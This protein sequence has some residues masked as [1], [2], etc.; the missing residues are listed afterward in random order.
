MPAFRRGRAIAVGIGLVMLVASFSVEYTVKRGDT[1]TKIAREH[2][3]SLSELISAN[4]LKNPD[5]IHPGQ[6]IVI[7]QKD[8]IHVVQR[9][10]TLIKLAAAYKT[11]VTTLVQANSIRNPDL[12]RVGQQLIIP[13]AAP[14]P[15]GASG[16]SPAPAPTS[17]GTR[18][19]AFHVVRSGENL[20]SIAARYPGVS[21]SQIAKANGII[22]GVIYTGT[23]LFL[24]GPEFVARA[25]GGEGVY[26]VKKGDRLGD[27][28]KAHGVT[29]SNLAQRN[30]ISNP[31]LIRVG[32]EL[33]VP[34]GSSWI[35]PVDGASVFNDWGFPRGATRFH[36]GNDLF[37]PHGTPVY[38]PVSG[39]IEQKV[40][41]IGGN[42][43]NLVGDDGV[44]YIGSHLSKFGKDGRVKA[45]DIVGYVGNTGNA[46]GTRPHLHFGMYVDGLVI[47]PYPTLVAHGCK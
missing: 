41:S 16:A 11:A 44:L 21:D 4:N 45:G 47:N 18:S 27:I 12:I 29:T 7:P 36:E 10:D 35:C 1:L 15:G 14:S 6:I 17:V 28:A 33:V 25:S 3:V 46:Q 20:A 30:N 22:D 9:G 38:A 19:G 43:F 31:N 37:A 8:T 2:G 39:V 5:L 40:G 23:R 24:D 13:G 32:Q 26:K 34:S 42:Q